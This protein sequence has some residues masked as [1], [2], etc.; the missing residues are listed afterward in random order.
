MAL[1]SLHLHEAVSENAVSVY[2]AN[3]GRTSDGPPATYDVIRQRYADTEPPAPHGPKPMSNTSTS[4]KLSSLNEQLAILA[5]GERR[6]ILA[7]LQEA[8]TNTASLDD[9]ASVLAP[10]SP[11]ERDYARIRLHHTHL[12][13]LAETPLLRY[14]P[15]TATVDYHGHPELEALLTTIQTHEAIYDSY[16]PH[17][18]P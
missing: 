9:L 5:D 15:N 6:A 4:S 17:S 10:D 13:K 7:H 14:D 1:G 11:T 16:S 12:P 2:F 3:S 8:G 18:E